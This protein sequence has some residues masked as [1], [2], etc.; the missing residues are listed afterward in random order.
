MSLL[1]AKGISVVVVD[2]HCH[3]SPAWYEPVE[4]LLH[5]MDRHSVAQA[6][7]IQINGQA[8]NSYQAECL[9]R[10]PGRFASVVIVDT[11]R[12]DASAVLAR[13]TEHG[14]SGIRLRPTVR[15]TGDDPLAIWRSAER[16]GLVVSCHGTPAEFGSADFAQLVQALPGL[17]IVI[18]HLASLGRPAG[19]PYPADVVEPVLALARFPNLTIKVP[20]LG[21]FCRRA[22]PVKEPFPFAEPI[23]PLLEQVYAAFGPDRMMWG[24]DF[25]PVSGREGY[26][27]ALRFPMEVL[28]S[29][30]DAAR[31]QIFGATAQRVF[32]LLS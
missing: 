23:P 9:H 6:V 16:L 10:F 28:A 4:S 29:K 32:R 1:V 13:E 11:A 30:G 31:E 2:T 14:A 26:A 7:L 12:A 24:S 15:S 3:A 25:P 19:E 20:G 5:Q 8:D 17:S 21:E 22:M 18:E 27:N